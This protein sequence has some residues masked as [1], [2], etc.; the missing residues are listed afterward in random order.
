MYR[1]HISPYPLVV[2]FSNQSVGG[3]WRGSAFVQEEQLVA[4]SGD[5][6][7]ILAADTHRIPANGGIYITPCRINA[8]WSATAVQRHRSGAQLLSPSRVRTGPPLP[9]SV[10]VLAVDAPNMNRRTT[11]DYA[12][13][14]HLTNK[15]VTLLYLAR[16]H[17]SVYT[18]L[19][20]GGAFRGNRPLVLLL[21]YVL[22][23]LAD[24]SEIRFHLFV[25]ESYSWLTSVE[26]E[27][28]I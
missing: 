1:T 20:G 14:W 9:K 12:T 27:K 2:T 24:G 19:L 22:Q 10:S 3:S 25:T 18:G 15:V 13:L 11:Y 6:M 17:P 26:I 21:H 23:Y 4:Q 28:R 8:W 7:A 16:G 5:L